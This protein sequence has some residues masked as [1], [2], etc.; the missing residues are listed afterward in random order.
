MRWRAGARLV[1]AAIAAGL[2]AGA[3]RAD[4]DYGQLK[5]T[6]SAHGKVLPDAK[7]MT[8]Y[9]YDEDMAGQSACYDSCAQNWPPALAEA[10]AQPVGD[11]TLVKRKDG[12]MQWADSGK[13]LY[14]FKNDKQPGDVTGDGKGGVWHAVMEKE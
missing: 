1:G 11:L 7:G 9:T 10:G 14:T 3:A 5:V 13:P 6:E 2:A 8:L 12:S 4:E